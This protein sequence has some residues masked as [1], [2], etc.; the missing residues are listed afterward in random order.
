[1]VCKLA[2]SRVDALRSEDSATKFF[3]TD[4]LRNSRCHLG[5]ADDHAEPVAALA[6]SGRVGGVEG[7]ADHVGVGGAGDGELG[8]DGE[9]WAVV[10]S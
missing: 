8:V 6:H 2:G 1:M 4:H 7:V 10:G 5:Y 3:C 9:E